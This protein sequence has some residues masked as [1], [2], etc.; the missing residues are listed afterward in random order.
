MTI[1]SLAVKLEALND[2]VADLSIDLFADKE[3]FTKKKEKLK[4]V[5]NELLFYSEYAQ[6][7]TKS[8]DLELNTSLLYPF[9]YVIDPQ[10]K[11]IFERKSIEE[12]KKDVKSY[13]KEV[14]TA[15][16]NGKID[17]KTFLAMQNDTIELATKQVER[18]QEEEKAQEEQVDIY[19]EYNMILD[20]IETTK[21]SFI[22]N[23]IGEESYGALSYKYKNMQEVERKELLYKT[24]VGLC[25]E[26]GIA[27]K[28]DFTKYDIKDEDSVTNEGYCIKTKDIN[29][30]PF[31]LDTILLEQTYKLYI[32]QILVNKNYTQN[33]KDDLAKLLYKSLAAQKNLIL[34]KIKKRELTPYGC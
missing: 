25:N 16:K 13:L 32:G 23:Q 20:Q 34:D 3:E 15:Y 14:E 1:V 8:E 12:Y 2:E 18:I 17:R 10:G 4:K 21:K 7:Y 31:P 28:M 6:L 29:N 24:H 9:E 11:R 30:I 5:Q 26:M 22:V 27:F 19:Q 33:Q